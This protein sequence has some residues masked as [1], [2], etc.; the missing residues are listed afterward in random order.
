[1]FQGLVVEQS[2]RSMGRDRTS[3]VAASFSTTLLRS[4]IPAADKMKM[5]PDDIASVSEAEGP[6]NAATTSWTI[7]AHLSMPSSISKVK[8]KV[9]TKQY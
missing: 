8:Q 7:T 3:S 6:F 5:K 9:I 4:A 1:M 2:M